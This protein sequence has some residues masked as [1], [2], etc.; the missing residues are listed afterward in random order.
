MVL[1][2]RVDFLKQI[3]SVAAGLVSRGKGTI[4]QGDMF[5]FRDG[6]AATFDEEV[7]R[8]V[9]T[10]LDLQGAVA[11]E[12]LLGLLKKLG[13]DELDLSVEDGQ[14]MVKGK[15]FR[16]GI[17]MEKDVALSTDSTEQPGDWKPLPDKFVEA[18]GIVGECASKDMSKFQ[19][20]C[21]HVHPEWVE[22]CDRFQIGRYPMETGLTGP[23]LVRRTSLAGVLAMGPKE[24]AETES[25]LHFRDGSGIQA[26]CRVYKQSYPDLGK[27][28]D[29]SGDRMK[30]PEGMEAE[31]KAA[32]VFSEGDTINQV[33]IEVK[34]GV[35][36][37]KGQGPFG[38]YHREFGEVRWE[39]KDVSFS[40]SPK[41]LAEVVRL[42][43]TIE[44]LPGKIKARTKDWTFVTCTTHGD[45]T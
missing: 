7:L 38:W 2:N 45:G 3:E 28:L 4:R 41:I 37:L 1:V 32:S 34:D 40:I 22:A 20:T 19:L 6:Q 10:S 11:G 33:T 30:L 35:L 25:W 13:H 23:L 24:F 17:R 18:I 8:S 27:Y 39:G 9:R 42:G 44:V 26:S 15:G 16:S 29:D 5:L 21:I 14:L 43:R 12:E 31:I 36:T